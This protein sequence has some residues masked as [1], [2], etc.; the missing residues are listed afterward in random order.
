MQVQR[1][2]T[3]VKVVIQGE[4]SELPG[5]VPRDQGGFM[6]ERSTLSKQ[7]F[8]RDPHLVRFEVETKGP[9]FSFSIGPCTLVIVLLGLSIAL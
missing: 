4:S 5:A 3:D 9:T 8:R 6:G 1:G 7:L 2:G